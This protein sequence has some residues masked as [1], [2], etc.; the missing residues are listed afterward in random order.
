MEQV[1]SHHAMRISTEV[2]RRIFKHSTG[3]GKAVL[4]LLPEEHVRG[5]RTPNG[6]PP[7]PSHTIT[8]H[9]DL[10]AALHDIRR[11]GSAIDDGEQE[12]GV[13]CVA[14]PV[15]A[16]NLR[17]ALPMS[18]RDARMSPDVVAQA[19]S[20]LPEASRQLAVELAERPSA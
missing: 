13:R 18:G 9:D 10:V 1:Q 5:A 6:P 4:P 14:V 3:V 16:A 20:K 19:I 12:V 7:Q 11:S 15:K 17:M 2:G 8:D